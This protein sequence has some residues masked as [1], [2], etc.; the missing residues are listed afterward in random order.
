M[1]KFAPFA[2]DY[3]EAT[4]GRIMD[5]LPNLYIDTKKLL[6]FTNKKVPYED[7]TKMVKRG[8]SYVP[9]VCCNDIKED[10]PVLDLYPLLNVGVA[11]VLTL[12]SSDNE[13][14]N[15]KFFYWLEKNI[16]IED[17]NDSLEFVKQWSD[18]SLRDS[19]DV[20]M[21]DAVRC[22]YIDNRFTTVKKI[23]VMMCA[24]RVVNPKFYCLAL[25][26]MLKLA[27]FTGPVLSTNRRVIGCKMRGNECLVPNTFYVETKRHIAVGLT[28]VHP[29]ISRRGSIKYFPPGHR[30]PHFITDC[31]GAGMSL[32]ALFAIHLFRSF[33]DGVG[34]GI[35]ETKMQAQFEEMYEVCIGDDY[36]GRL[37]TE[38]GQTL[39]R[40]T[41]R[42]FFLSQQSDTIPLDCDVEYTVGSSMVGRGMLEATILWKYAVGADKFRHSFLVSGDV[43]YGNHKAVINVC[44]T[45]LI[46]D[47]D[48]VLGKVAKE[49]ADN[50]VSGLN[51]RK[52]NEGYRRDLEKK[53]SAE[54]EAL[55]SALESAQSECDKLRGS[56]DTLQRESENKRTIIEN[57]RGEVSQLQ[58][59][60]RNTYSDDVS[61][62]DVPVSVVSEAE[63]LDFVN[64]FRIVVIGGFDT[65]Q[66][67]LEQAGFT[68][69]YFADALNVTGIVGD[70]FCVCTRFVS[71]K[72]VYNFESNYSSQLDSFFYYNG[73]NAD[74]FL[75]TCYEF[76]KGWFDTE[77]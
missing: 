56:L 63:M 46:K 25:V 68:N 52:L 67:R 60:V 71:H 40:C 24:L 23:Y 20:V 19:P 6:C 51:L 39:T 76:I 8:K 28:V 49:S 73:T 70:F 55:Q 44:N 47:I 75:R 45:L 69:L 41:D 61:E 48:S 3:V 37:L 38:G 77:S 62:D 11:E 31:R 66:S 72:M 7:F 18:K 26:E 2:K 13:F 21:V 43:Y 9:V 16:T 54:V 50:A 30:T 59:K 4:G 74:V 32:L 34:F 22:S 29:M 10:E 36:I 15:L 1:A 5:V 17:W 27:L 14:W 33:G 65:L 53:H 35:R 42:E 57:L 64:Q 58:S 12:L